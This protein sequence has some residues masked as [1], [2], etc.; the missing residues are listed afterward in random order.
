MMK[1]IPKNGQL[2]EKAFEKYK[3]LEYL[4]PH[5][6]RKSEEDVQDPEPEKTKCVKT[7]IFHD[8]QVKVRRQ[9]S[10]YQDVYLGD[11]FGS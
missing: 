6:E 5:D 11:L 3:N 8:I 4:N 9:D 2:L 10:T 1:A 7:D